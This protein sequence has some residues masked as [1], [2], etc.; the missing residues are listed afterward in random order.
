MKKITL[1]LVAMLLCGISFSQNNTPK[2]LVLD[3]TQKVFELPAA[4]GTCMFK[5]KGKGC[6]LAV[7]Y[8]KQ[9]YFVTGTSIDDHGDAHAKEGFCNAIRKAKV[10]G[11]VKDEKFAVTYFELV[12]PKE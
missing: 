9:Y 3:S 7:E 5:M 1:F 2:K 8:N 12:K 4:C 11:V 6:I 10:Q